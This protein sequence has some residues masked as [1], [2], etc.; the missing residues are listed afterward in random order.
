LGSFI[1]LDKH[2]NVV[3]G[4]RRLK[5]DP[6]WP[7]IRLDSIKSD[8]QRLVARLIATFVGEMSHTME[9]SR[10]LGAWRTVC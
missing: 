2:G 8:E 3:D 4:L 5:A 6:N 7:K 1:L 9:K 10:I